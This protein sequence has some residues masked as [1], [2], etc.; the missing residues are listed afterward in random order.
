MIYLDNAATSFPKAPGVAEA[1]AA[2]I[3]ALPGSVG[4]AS[5]PLAREA[6][7]VLYYVRNQAATFL[8]LPHPERLVFTRNAT[9]GLNI[10]IRGCLGQGGRV[11]VSD[12]EHNSVMRPLRY[13]ESTVG[14]RVDILHLD[15]EGRPDPLELPTQLGLRPDLLVLTGASNVSGA[16]P[17]VS[18]ILAAAH[19]H[20]VPVLVDASQLAGHAPA[21]FSQMGA[22]YLVLPGHKGL[23][24]PAGTGILWLAPGRDVPALIH[25]GTGSASDREI[26]PEILPDRLEAGTHNLASL[27]G[28]GAALGWLSAQGLARIA[29]REAELCLALFEGLEGL[30]GLRIL[31]PG[32]GRPRT[33]LISLVSDIL[34]LD[35]LALAL[36]RQGIAT[37]MGLHCAPLAHRSLGSLARGGALRLSP[38]PFTTDED[39]HRT[40]RVFQ[41]VLQ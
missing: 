22:D 21:D 26:Q 1:V 33:A 40:L 37:R 3:I 36:D 20:G 18:E 5:H 2:S 12:L 16:L 19:S 27:A 24:G 7:R 17:P 4:R 11:L 32:R 28:L 39:I 14:L 6:A 8:G 41:E 31:G 9:E 38:G 15:P 30:P 29:H 13:L 10:V 35:E 25:G 23:L 34:P